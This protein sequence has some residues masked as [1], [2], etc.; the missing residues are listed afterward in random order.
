LPRDLGR[1]AI[2]SAWDIDDVF[3]LAMTQRFAER[4]QLEPQIAFVNGEAGPCRVEQSAM[5][6]DLTRMLEQMH[7]DIEGSAADLNRLAVSFQLSSRFD[8]AVRSKRN[9]PISHAI[10]H[11]GGPALKVRNSAVADRAPSSERY[12]SANAHVVPLL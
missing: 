10:S 7:E 1:E 3:G 8:D 6:Y 2:A 11:F 9:Y 4:R 5:T 12:R